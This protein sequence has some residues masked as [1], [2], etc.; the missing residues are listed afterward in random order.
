MK[1]QIW[2]PHTTVA[3]V[4]EHEGRF[5]LIEEQTSDGLK[6]NQPAGHLDEHETLVDA[7][8]REA[9]EEAAVHFRPQ[10]LVGVY[11]WRAPSN[12]VTYLRFAFAGELLGHEPER[13]LDS[14]IVRSL[15]LSADEIERSAHRQRSPLVWACVSDYLAGR[16]FA[17]DLIRHF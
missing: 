14:G 6:L 12:G 8:A 2:T 9:L 16:R 15:W 1:T 13:P 4:I 17:L 7:C 5:L 3:A 11:Q 10:S